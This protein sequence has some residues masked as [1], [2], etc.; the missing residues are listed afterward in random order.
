MHKHEFVIELFNTGAIKFGQFVLKS[1]VTSPFYVN[2]RQIISYP[3]LMNA[4]TDLII[5]QIPEGMTFDRIAGVPYSG[6]PIASALSLK[7]NKPM[8]IQRKEEKAYGTKDAFIGEYKQGDTC[9]LI[10]DIITSGESILQAAQGFS[11]AGVK[12][13][14]AFVIVDRRVIRGDFHAKHGIHLFPL[15]NMHEVVSILRERNLISAEQ[16]EQ[17]NQYLTIPIPTAST[18]ETPAFSNSLTRKLVQTM[19]KKRTNIVLSLDVE[20]SSNFFTVLDAI[21]DEIAMVKTHID[22]LKDFSVSFINDLIAFCSERHLHLF[23]DRKF[24]DIGNT[25]RLQYRS[26][27]YR[28]S[29]WAEF[30]TVHLIA[31][32]S[33]LK[34]LF[35]GLEDRSSFLLARMSSRDN[36]ISEDYTRKVLEIGRNNPNVVSGFI[37]HGANETE[38]GLLKKKIPA[39]FLLL[40]PGV[41]LAAKGDALGQTYITPEVAVRGGA[42]CVIVGRGITHAPHPADAARE[43]REIAW[44]EYIKRTL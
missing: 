26:G 21:A 17:I 13:T 30:V 15:L 7:L 4:L 22:I 23:E 3:P 38:I 35:D 42:D 34:G 39:G 28:I 37:G 33:I 31:G 41:Q 16:A 20:E 43:Y 6:I 11:E 1:G 2:L 40:M 32:S 14:S 36:L 25:V 24:A 27:V 9:L 5:G 18:F 44:N 29:D 8:I 10:E 12:V 19:K